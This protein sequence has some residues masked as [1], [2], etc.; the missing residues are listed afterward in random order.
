MDVKSLP[1]IES[2]RF[3]GL[4]FAHEGYD[5]TL[6]ACDFEFPMNSVVWVK[7]E[8]GAGKTSLLQVMAGLL[9]PQ[10]GS[11]FLN[12]HDVVPMSFEEFLPYRLKIGFTFDYGGLINNRSIFD[13]IILPLNYHDLLSPAD[14][15]HRVKEMIERF[16]LGKYQKER[17]AHVPGRVRKL[18]VLLRGLIAY[19]DMLLLDDPSIGLGDSTQ[20]AFAELLK[21]LHQQGHVK[22]LFV[23]SHDERFMNLF[24]HQIIHLSEGLLYKQANVTERIVVNG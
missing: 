14:A 20:M 19:P 4:T 8:E 6:R 13:N 23:S 3:E 15:Q 12:D 11:Y 1:S 22:H 24:S 5:P 17:P 2:I 21:E 18:A 10:G 9:I 16:D 7:S